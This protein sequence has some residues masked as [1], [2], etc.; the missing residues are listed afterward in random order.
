VLPQ[1]VAADITGTI[2]PHGMNVI[3][4]VLRVVILDEEG[5]PLH[6]TV[7]WLADFERAIL[8]GCQGT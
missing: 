8:F 5:R 2:T 7:V 3:P 4:V 6:T 1:H